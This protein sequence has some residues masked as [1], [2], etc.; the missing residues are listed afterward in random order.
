MSSSEQ[1]YERATE[2]YFAGR[3]TEAL[4]AF[5]EAIRLDPNGSDPWNSKGSVL[6]DLGR[7]NEALQAFEEAIRLDPNDAYQGIVHI[8]P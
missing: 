2:A 3:Y 6:L 4:Q 5:D 7:Y 8:R 1:W